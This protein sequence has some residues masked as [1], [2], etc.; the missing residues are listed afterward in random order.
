MATQLATLFVRRLEVPVVLRD[1]E[2]TRIDE[3]LAAVREEVGAKEPSSRRSST[4][5]RLE[6]FEGCDLVLEAVFE[7]LD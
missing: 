3:A 1:I 4:A 6:Q 7:E 5:A 2:Q